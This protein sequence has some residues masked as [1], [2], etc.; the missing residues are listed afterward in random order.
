[1]LSMVTP[2]LFTVV[3]TGTET[4]ATVTSCIGGSDLNLVLVPMTTASDLSGD[5]VVLAKS[6]VKTE[7]ARTTVQQYSADGTV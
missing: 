7:F 1:M 3:V 6:K 4:P 5:K 2:R